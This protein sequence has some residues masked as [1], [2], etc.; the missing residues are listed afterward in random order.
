[1]LPEERRK[2]LDGIVGQMI[3]NKETDA[4]IQFVV[5]DFKKK[6]SKQEGLLIEQKKQMPI[7]TNE[8]GGFGTA[9][10]DVAVGAI[11]GGVESLQGIGK[12]GLEAVSLGKIDT[13]KL[14][15]SDETL[16]SK[17]RGEQVGKVLEFGGEL[18][19]GFTKVAV[20]LVKPLLDARKEAVATQKVIEM[21]S[22]KATV[23]EAK[24]AQTQGRFVEGKARTLFRSGTADKILP[25]QKTLS[26][27]ETINKN[28]PN[29]GKMSE[30]QLFKAIDQ[31]ITK[32]AN[33]L[34][35]V[36]EKTPIKTETIQ[37]IN[38][39]W[40][41][42][43]KN[44]IA[45]A[46]ATEEIN[47][48]KRQSKFESLLK[49]SGSNSHADLWDTR[50]T[51]DNSIPEAVKRANSL[52]P[53]SLQLQKQEWLENRAILNDAIDAQPEFKQMSELYNAREGILSK[54]KVDK[55]QVS[56]IRELVNKYPEIKGTIKLLIGAEALRRIT[57]IDLIP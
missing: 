19:A 49:K 6:Y 48:I 21:I 54:T 53:E 14:G 1:M 7:L 31:N 15:I 20:P 37:K 47:V 17:S 8:Q 4:N 35:P 39:D 33:K 41:I 29:A 10:K 51:Y 13:S 55:A 57:G 45:D 38:D 34:R 46:P 42:L 28:I 22:P 30:D 25:S 43:K 12:L 24:L 16:K 3:A 40:A 52:S 9:L 5:D 18:G 44:Q 23:K 50:I 32:T 56:K 36:M 11:K 2:Q 27:A 26:A